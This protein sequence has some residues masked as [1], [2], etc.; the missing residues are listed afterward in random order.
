MSR[1]IDKGEVPR[2][3][4]VGPADDGDAAPLS[5]RAYP[6]TR[7]ASV[8]ALL[9]ALGGMSGCADLRKRQEVTGQVK[10]KGQP[11]ED[12]IIDFTPLDGQETGE[13]AL[14]LKGRYRIPREKGLSPGKYR[15]A[16]VS[17]NGTPG[18]GDAGPVS[19]Y[20]GMK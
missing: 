3:D 13:G 4:P 19:P 8:C 16:I 11:V 9:L 12:G 20:V 17:V 1:R 15:V 18:D 7:R 6:M 14:I 5:S 2:R 10:Y